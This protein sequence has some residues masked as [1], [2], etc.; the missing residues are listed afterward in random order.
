MVQSRNTAILK[1][2]TRIEWGLWTCVDNSR[3]F[4]HPLRGRLA[5]G[6]NHLKHSKLLY[7]NF[8]LNNVLQHQLF[9]FRSLHYRVR[10]CFF[11]LFSFHVIHV[12]ACVAFTRQRSNGEN[13]RKHGQLC[14]ECVYRVVVCAIE[15]W[16]LKLLF[17][18]ILQL[19]LLVLEKSLIHPTKF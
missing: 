5:S 8:R 11:F 17:A 1:I 6:R 12:C 18:V 7:C 3:L 15:H 9:V 4:L 2:S 19:L 10:R 16:A 13:N 14:F